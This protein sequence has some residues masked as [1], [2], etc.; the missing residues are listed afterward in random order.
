[1]IRLMD[2]ALDEGDADDFHFEPGHLDA[3]RKWPNHLFPAQDG[4]SGASRLVTS[5]RLETRRAAKLTSAKSVFDVVWCGKPIGDHSYNSVL[6]IR[7]NGNE[8]DMIIKA[9]GEVPEADRWRSMKELITGTKKEKE[10][11]LRAA[12]P[13]LFGKVA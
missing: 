1:M 5:Q 4:E 11:K 8:A 12:V 10:A 9:I 3:S 7:L 13:H 6:A 2:I